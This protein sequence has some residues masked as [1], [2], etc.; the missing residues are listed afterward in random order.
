M[1][2]SDWSSDVCSSDLGSQVVNDRQTRRAD[3]GEQAAE[4]ADE[5]REPDTGEYQTGRDSETEHDL[6]AIGAQCTDRVAVEKEIGRA[7]GRERVSRYVK[8]S[9]GAVS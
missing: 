7:S 1:R 6:A 5:Q 3:G 8:I 2:I 9:E 4:Q